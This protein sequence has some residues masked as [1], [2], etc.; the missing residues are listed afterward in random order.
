MRSA[1]SLAVFTVVLAYRPAS[2]PV[3]FQTQAHSF[4]GSQWSAPVN[5]GST[6][7]STTCSRPWPRMG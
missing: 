6:I 2:D 5:L 4:A 3:A 7:N 1:C